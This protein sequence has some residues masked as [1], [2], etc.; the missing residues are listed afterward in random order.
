MTHLRKLGVALVPA[1]ALD[2]FT[3][4]TPTAVLVRQVLGATGQFEKATTVA[5]L[6]AARDRKIAALRR[7]ASTVRRRIHLSTVRSRRPRFSL[8]FL[9]IARASPYIL[10]RTVATESRPRQ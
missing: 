7:A 1:T 5:K 4:D 8:A 9:G 2:F 10:N 6:K 3:E